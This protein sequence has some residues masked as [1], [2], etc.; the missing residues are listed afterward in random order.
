MV[1]C[2]AGEE[3]G[4]VSGGLELL[5]APPAPVAACVNEVE[6]KLMYN[7]KVQKIPFLKRDN[8][9]MKLLG[10]LHI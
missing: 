9:S 2:P 7:Q 8:C 10:A 5:G 4:Q 1:C 6:H 3:K